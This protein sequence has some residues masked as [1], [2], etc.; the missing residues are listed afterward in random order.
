MPI[1]RLKRIEDAT[2]F[3]PLNEEEYSQWWRGPYKGDV[4]GNIRNRHGDRRHIP[5][6]VEFPFDQS[7][8]SY[9]YDGDERVFPVAVD[10]KG[11]TIEIITLE[12]VIGPDTAAIALPEKY[13]KIRWL[14]RGQVVE[15]V[16]EVARR[17]RAGRRR[18]AHMNFRAALE[19]KIEVYSNV[20]GQYKTEWEHWSRVFVVR[21]RRGTARSVFRRYLRR[22]VGDAQAVA[23]RAVGKGE[24]AKITVSG[25]F[26]VYGEGD[27]L[28]TDVSADNAK[29]VPDKIQGIVA[30]VK[31]LA[32]PF[33]D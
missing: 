33:F 4:V 10:G 3:I 12:T 25:S 7:D 2:M 1:K 14:S 29:K 31:K 28:T 23:D 24:E 32:E 26:G 8:W 22:L 5:L 18:F 21:I 30:Q 11:N 6:G 16:S 20:V 17:E 13:G 19:I 27:K 15:A 9:N